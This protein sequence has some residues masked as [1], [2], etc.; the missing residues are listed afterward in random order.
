MSECINSPFR[1]TFQH[2]LDAK[3]RVAVPAGWRPDGTLELR[4]RTSERAGFE[5]LRFFTKEALD[6][7]IRKIANDDEFTEGEKRDFIG[8]INESVT[9]LTINSQGKIQIPKRDIE[10]QNLKADVVIVG[11]GSEFEIHR[12]DIHQKIR[13]KEAPRT[14]K[15]NAKYNI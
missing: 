1:G 11:R 6:T 15:L 10:D 12:P 2:K 8:E 4:L 3:G 14:R 9:D 5:I 13:E 7:V